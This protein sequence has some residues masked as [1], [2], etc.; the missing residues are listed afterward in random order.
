MKT[1]KVLKIDYQGLICSKCDHAII[2]EAN[3]N[4]GIERKQL[5]HITMDSNGSTKIITISKDCWC[6]CMEARD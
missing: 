3:D 1:N 5:E 4:K 2:W 6:G